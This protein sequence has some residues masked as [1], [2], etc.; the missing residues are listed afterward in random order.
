[1]K[2]ILLVTIFMGNYKILEKCHYILCTAAYLSPAIPTTQ[3]VVSNK[4]NFKSSHLKF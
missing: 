3:L 2:F 4:K 1:M